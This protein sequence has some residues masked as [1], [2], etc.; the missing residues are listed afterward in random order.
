[1]NIVV[2]GSGR[3]GSDLALQLSDEG[4][5]VI[6][7]DRNREAF[8]RLGSGFTGQ[9][10]VGSGFDREVLV[11]ANVADADAFAAVTNGDNTNI[12]CARIAMEKYGIRNVVARIYDPQRAVIYKRLGIPTVP[13]VQWTTSQVKRW[14]VP[15]DESI[16][17]TDDTASVHLVERILPDHLAG[18]AYHALELGGGARVVG[19]VRG[20]S[21]RLDVE[22]LFAQEDDVVH[23]L[24]PRDG[25]TALNESLGGAR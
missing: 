6:V 11:A 25:V 2:I 12:L 13:T 22:T 17:W 24:V 19:I 7:V 14:I 4:H 10:I 9:K 20:G 5:H 21:P 16:A 18:R 1:V 23:F 3:V 8:R 15:V